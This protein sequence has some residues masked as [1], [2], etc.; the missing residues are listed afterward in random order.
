M[1]NLSPPPILII[2]DEPEI[3]HSLRRLL[4]GEFDVHTALNGFEALDLLRRKLVH[5]ILC[6]QRMPD[7]TGVEFLAQ[8]EDDY[9]TIRRMMFSGYADI[10]AVIDAI[11]QG[12]I[13]RY[14][15]KPWDPDELRVVLHTA[16]QEYNQVL[17]RNTLLTEL[18]GRVAHGL[19]LSD[20]LLRE[21]YGILNRQGK[22]EVQDFAQKEQTLLDWLDRVMAFESA[23]PAD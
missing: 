6:D 13:S 2:D 17:E 1:A 11:N 4:H 9:P 15:R 3:L 7:M 23:P 16:C 21:Q 20:E 18:R 14:I 22:V 8:V 12:H 19:R 10:Q 5:V